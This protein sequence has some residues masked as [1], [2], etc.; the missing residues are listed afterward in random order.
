M[1]G[2]LVSCLCKKLKGH[3]VRFRKKADLKN[4]LWN[5]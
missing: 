1:T 2:N 4:G 3:F 5:S